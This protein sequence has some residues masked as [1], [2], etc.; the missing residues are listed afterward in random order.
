MKKPSVGPDVYSAGALPLSS[1]GVPD[2]ADGT[3]D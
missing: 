3:Q 2:I 1:T